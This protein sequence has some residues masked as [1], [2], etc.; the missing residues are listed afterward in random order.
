MMD[1]GA[2][3][4]VPP[5]DHDVHALGRASAPGPDAE[6]AWRQPRRAIRSTPVIRAD[7]IKLALKALSARYG[8]HGDELYMLECARHLQASYVDQPVLAP[9]HY[10]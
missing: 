9:R 8:F 10:D 6:S 1:G 4:S 2:Q 3:G 5:A 7:A